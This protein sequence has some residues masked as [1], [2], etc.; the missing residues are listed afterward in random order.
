M[1]GFTHISPTRGP[2]I[3]LRP[4]GAGFACLNSR[5]E[6]D[7]AGNAPTQLEAS[8]H[9]SRFLESDFNRPLRLCFRDTVIGKQTV[10]AFI[11][12]LN[13][14]RCPA[15]VARFV[16]SVHVDSV[17]RML[18]GWF[19]SKFCKELLV[20]LKSKFDASTA[21]TVVGV[22]SG[23]VTSP[24]R[25][26]EGPVFRHG[27]VSRTFAVLCEMLTRSLA[28][29]ASARQCMSAFQV[30]T[31]NSFDRSTIAPNE[32]IDLLTVSTVNAQNEN[33]TEMLTDQILEIVSGWGERF[34]RSVQEDLGHTLFYQNMRF[35]SVNIGFIAI[36]LFVGASEAYSQTGTE[37]PHPSGCV[38]LSRAAAQ[39]ALEAGDKAKALEVQLKAEQ[40][41]K[42]LIRKALE[43]M[44]IEFARMSGE[45]TAL[46]QNSVSDRAIIELLLQ[47]VKKKR[48]AFITLF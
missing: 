40:D 34:K 41:A 37:C 27:V 17:E 48:N 18:R 29:V 23:I 1:Q 26:I 22:I 33:S 32:P 44:R 31:R 28:V 6:R 9:P 38:V 25:R 2:S 35:K 36:L 21:V 15:D 8:G 19:S 30:A 24:F 46:K 4:V 16:V 20:R 14:I 11:L 39:A 7:G 47:N 3:R 5:L 10:V 42:E 12:A 43:D 45:N 13:F